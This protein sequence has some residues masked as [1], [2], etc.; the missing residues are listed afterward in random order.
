MRCI[1]WYNEAVTGGRRWRTLV[2]VPARVPAPDGRE[3]ELWDLVEEADQIE[4]SAP[5]APAQD[6]LVAA[7]DAVLTALA[8]RDRLA[9]QV[10]LVEQALRRPRSWLRPVLRGRLV[11]QLRA[12]RAAE[13]AAR[14]RA[15]RDQVRFTQLRRAAVRRRD[16][17]A[18]HRETLAAARIARAELDQRIDEII[19][20]YA[21]MA[22]PPAWFRFGLGYPPRPEQQADWL[23]RARAEIAKRRRYGAGSA[24]PTAGPVIT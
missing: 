22:H 14:V 7:R 17:L 13:E 5:P 3:R 24:P 12:R 4:A 9:R 20:G 6:E 21:R 8:Q 11:G 15:E 23:G 2:R 19:D 18:G 1:F 16:Y 10:A